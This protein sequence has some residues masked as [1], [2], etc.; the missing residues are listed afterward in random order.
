MTGFT[1]VLASRSSQ[2]DDLMDE[3]PTFLAPSLPADV[4]RGFQVINRPFSMMEFVNSPKHIKSQGLE[5][6]LPWFQPQPHILAFLRAPIS[7]NLSAAGHKEAVPWPAR[8]HRKAPPDGAH[9]AR[10]DPKRGHA[11]NDFGVLLKWCVELLTLRS[12]KGAAHTWCLHSR[13]RRCVHVNLAWLVARLSEALA[14]LSAARTWLR[15]AGAGVAQDLPNTATPDT[16]VGFFFPYMD[17]TPPD[18][19]AVVKRFY[20]EGPVTDLYSTGPSPTLMHVDILRKVRPP[21]APPASAAP[22]PAPPS[23]TWTYSAR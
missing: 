14:Q 20:T 19:A 4:H 17:P 5:R 3:M 23:C 16:V 8:W 1:R 9:M 18:M 2:P 12:N 15:G 21:S 11:R 7:H 13:A 6:N 22:G 10:S